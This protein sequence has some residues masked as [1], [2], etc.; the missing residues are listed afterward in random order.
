M[1]SFLLNLIFH[2]LRVLV[3]KIILQNRGEFFRHILAV[4]RAG[5]LTGRADGV[6]IVWVE[7]PY[8]ERRGAWVGIIGIKE[9]F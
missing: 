9:D 4:V 7:F 8:N 5:L 3:S 2:D 6:C 1:A